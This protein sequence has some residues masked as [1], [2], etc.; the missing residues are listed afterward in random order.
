MLAASASWVDAENVGRPM[1]SRP[2]SSALSPF[3]AADATDLDAQ[4]AILESHDVEV[5]YNLVAMLSAKGDKP[6]PWRHGS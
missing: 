5:V 3:I 2:L 6:I 4:R 1:P